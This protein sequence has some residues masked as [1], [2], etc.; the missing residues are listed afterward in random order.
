MGA[1]VLV[2]GVVDFGAAMVVVVDVVG[3]AVVVAVVEVVVLHD[4]ITSERAI[5]PVVSSIR[6]WILSGNRFFKFLLFC[7]MLVEKSK[8]SRSVS[9]SRCSLEIQGQSF[10]LQ[11][12]KIV[13]I[14]DNIVILTLQFSHYRCQV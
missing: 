13:S 3:A 7:R 11:I 2:R 10:P 12:R 8:I 14:L 1:V 6:Q 5:R 4:A 9:F